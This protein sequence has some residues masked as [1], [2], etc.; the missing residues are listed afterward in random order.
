MR[1]PAL[2]LRTQIILFNTLMLAALLLAM[3]FALQFIARGALMRQLDRELENRFN[4]ASAGVPLPRLFPPD[5]P[6]GPP[7]GER[8]HGPDDGEHHHREEGNRPPPPEG[9]PPR[10]RQDF[11]LLYFSPD[12]K[13]QSK[14]AQSGDAA[15]YDANAIKR[16]VQR[17]ERTRSEAPGIPGKY[18]PL[19]V[20]TVPVLSEV[21]AG[22]GMVMQIAMPSEEID[23][24]MR[25]L[26]LALLSLLPISL[27]AAG[28]GGAFLTNRV[29]QPVRTATRAAAALSADAVTHED[30]A[31]RRLPVAGN[32]E[33][34]E[35]A[36]TFNGLLDRVA[37]AFQKQEKLLEQQRCFTADASH[38][39]K[40]PLTVIRGNATYALGLPENGSNTA[41]R[42]RET[43]TEI[44]AAAE[45]MSGLVQDLLLLARADSG[46]LAKE[47]IPLPPQEIIER[48]LTR[49]RA[50]HPEAAQ[51]NLALP[52]DL[53]EI[54]GNADEL[55][56]LFANLLDNALRHT[57]PAGKIT[58]DA[59][60]EGDFVRFTVC[61]T[62][63]GIAPEHLARL[64]ERFYRPDAARARGENASGGS[65]LGLAICRSIA[66][67]HGG[68]L[69][70]ESEVSAGTRVIVVIRQ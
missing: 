9:F 67:A 19:R 34:S 37:T 46:N 11:P 38:E 40:T 48:A 13:P 6:H 5:F 47:K 58:V 44:A 43:L 20:L 26:N 27:I 39:L 7:P 42:Q 16:A 56:R 45:D 65:G 59:A 35:L 36:T 14:E 10:F 31:V 50:A 30:N 41:T 3:G 66:E 21:G 52:D 12:G 15:P 33:F 53:P 18:P 25:G 57:P 49:V 23:R 54:R 17:G 63:E 51:V 29:L 55:M 28:A 62:G 64:G 70:I 24:A 1:F 69:T 8:G 61:D 4:L 22:I 2:S 60:P 68:A 32:D